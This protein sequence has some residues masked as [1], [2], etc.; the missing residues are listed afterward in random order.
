MLLVKKNQNGLVPRLHE[1]QIFELL[2]NLGELPHDDHAERAVL[3]ALLSS[4][5]SISKIGGVFRPDLF[6]RESHR[7][8]AAALMDLLNN[9]RGLDLVTLCQELERLGQIDEIGGRLYLAELMGQFISAENLPYHVQILS[10]KEVQRRRITLAAKILGHAKSSPDE[11]VFENLL[12]EL[13]ST[14]IRSGSKEPF[15]EV[16]AKD[17]QMPE[18]LIDGLAYKGSLTVVAGISGSFKSLFV[19]DRLNSYRARSTYLV[20]LDLSGAM[21]WLR[22]QQMKS[23]GTV[24]PVRMNPNG[25]LLADFKSRE[26]W[27]ALGRHVEC[28]ASSIIVFD[29]LLDFLDGDFSRGGDLNRPLQFCRDFASRHQVAVVLITHTTK[30]SWRRDEILLADVADSRVVTTK[31][32]LVLGFQYGKGAY[33]TSLLR[34]S[35]LKFRFGALADPVVYRVETPVTHPAGI[36]EFVPTS[37]AFPSIE[38]KD[39]TE[40]AKSAISDLTDFLQDGKRPASEVQEYLRQQGHSLKII[41]SAREKICKQPVKEGKFWYWELKDKQLAQDALCLGEGQV[42]QLKMEEQ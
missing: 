28:Y 8:I 30:S 19:Q 24:F 18:V 31:A 10:E 37:E 42:G 14:A 41:R 9:Q 2:E 35:M 32:D 39:V 36:F 26:F 38:N 20:D 5:I 34:V 17:V 25:N 4:P 16:S 40:A 23:R 13:E 15:I 7:I 27:R 6:Y 3:A 12:T 11:T 33:G 1:R 29:T 21:F 22:Q